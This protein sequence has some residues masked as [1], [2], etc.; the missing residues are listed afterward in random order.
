MSTH[1]SFYSTDFPVGRQS[2]VHFAQVGRLIHFMRIN[3]PIFDQSVCHCFKQEPLDNYSS[4]SITSYMTLNFVPYCGVSYLQ[5]TF[6]TIYSKMEDS[7]SNDNPE[8][9]EL[10]NLLEKIA[11]NPYEY[12]N[13]VAYINLLGKGGDAEDLRQAREVFHSLYPFSEGIPYLN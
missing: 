12:D 13:H 8:I 5:I 3:H 6:L 1:P 11:E 4:I 7:P 9:L 10:A 2:D